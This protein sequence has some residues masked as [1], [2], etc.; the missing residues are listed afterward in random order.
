MQFHEFKKINENEPTLILHKAWVIPCNSSLNRCCCSVR[1]R[2]K[3]EAQNTKE[4][5]QP[6]KIVTNSN[7]VNSQAWGENEF[8][9]LFTKFIL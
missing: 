3:S 2:M 6:V 7:M 1:T 4:Q 8:E 5:L 9:V